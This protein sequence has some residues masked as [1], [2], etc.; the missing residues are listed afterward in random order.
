MSNLLLDLKYMYLQLLFF[1]Q[2]SIYV[3]ELGTYDLIVM[4][5]PW[6]NGSVKRQK[7]SVD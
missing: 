1:L 6:T 4:D 2:L 3:S 7:K 5:P